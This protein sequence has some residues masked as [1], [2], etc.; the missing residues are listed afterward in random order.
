M[1][2][3]LRRSAMVLTEIENA[4]LQLTERER[5]VLAEHLLD[6]LGDDSTGLNEERWIAEAERRYREYK[7]GRLQARS[8][9]DA[10]RD[11]YRALE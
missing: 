10:F 2:E 1:L 7:A 4:A 3:R 5:A 9:D 8:A 6:S 11:A